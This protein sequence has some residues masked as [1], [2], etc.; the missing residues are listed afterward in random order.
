MKRTTIGCGEHKRQR[1]AEAS[2]C[3]GCGRVPDCQGC[4]EFT[5]F[6]EGIED[7][8]YY[9]QFVDSENHGNHVQPMI[10]KMR[11]DVDKELAEFSQDNATHAIQLANTLFEAAVALTAMATKSKTITEE[12]KAKLRALNQHAWDGMA[13]VN[14]Y[15]DD[16]EVK[17]ASHASSEDE[18]NP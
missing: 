17:P 18:A 10:K 16:E 9:R 3:H 12:E 8:F 7:K 2:I 5:A 13:M 4:M 14:G 1:C 11:A 6:V 15:D